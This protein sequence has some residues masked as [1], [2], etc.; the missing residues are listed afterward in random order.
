MSAATS[1]LHQPGIR[2]TRGQD[3]QSAVLV[4]VRC[5]E[6]RQNHL[7]FRRLTS[8][9]A[10][11]PCKLGA[12]DLISSLMVVT[13]SLNFSSMGSDLPK[14]RGIASFVS[15]WPTD[16]NDYGMIE[17]TVPKTAVQDADVWHQ[18]LCCDFHHAKVSLFVFLPHRQIYRESNIQQHQPKSSK[19]IAW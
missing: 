18:V 7:S 10:A 15:T 17:V 9:K 6:G 2:S 8:A 5:P 13:F 4:G 3:A 1:S 19:V 11:D 14:Y 12:L 16:M